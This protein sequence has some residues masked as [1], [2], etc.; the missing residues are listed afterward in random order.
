MLNYGLL[1]FIQ[2]GYGILVLA[3][4]EVDN[5][6]GFFDHAI[7]LIV[8]LFHAHDVIIPSLL[9]KLEAFKNLLLCT[10]FKQEEVFLKTL[11]FIFKFSDSLFMSTEV[12][13]DAWSLSKCLLNDI[14][15][16]CCKLIIEIV[17]SFFKSF[18]L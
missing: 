9:G 13:L 2:M 10:I 5:F 18:F 3:F 1:L 8:H 17:L 12:K 7:V 4:Y 16:D 14:L 6:L 15:L 11:D